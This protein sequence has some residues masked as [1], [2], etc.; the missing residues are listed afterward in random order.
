MKYVAKVFESDPVTVQARCTS[1]GWEY[2]NG[3]IFVEIPELGFTNPDLVYCQYGLAVPYLKVEPEDEVLVEPTINDDERWF[4]TGLVDCGRSA[5]SPGATDQLIALFEDGELTI[6]FNDNI[7]VEWDSTAKTLNVTVG[8]STISVSD[9][10]IEV[11]SGGGASTEKSVLG[12][13]QKGLLDQTNDGIVAITVP[14]PLGPL[15]PPVNSATFVT[16]KA[17]HPT[18]LSAGVKNN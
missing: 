16:I 14:S 6:N 1:N 5:V 12:E 2:H 10:L 8:N 4:Y 18:M 13:T 3:A 7:K 9:T 15:G 11:D 17:Q